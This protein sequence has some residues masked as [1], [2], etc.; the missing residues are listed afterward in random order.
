METTHLTIMLDK[1]LETSGFSGVISVRQADTVLYE[2][3]AGYADR[4]NRILNTLETRFGIASGTKFFT[5]LAIGRLIAAQKLNFATK[6]KDCL[7]LPFPRYSP[8]ITIGH[9]LT[10]TSGIPDY[11]D[12]EKITDFN[13]FHLAIPWYALKGPRDYLPL[14]PDEAMKFAPGERFSYSNG[15]YILLGVVIEELTGRKYQDFVEQEIFKTIGMNHSGYFALNKLPEKTAVGYIEEGEGW[16]TN[17]YNL[18]IV[19]ASDGGAFTTVEDITA[20]W[21]AFWRNEIIPKELVEIYAQPYIKAGAKRK[22]LSYGQGLWISEDTH[23]HRYE[24]IT[25]SDAGVSFRSSVHRSIELQI[26]VISNTSH[27]VWPIWR[28]IAAALENDTVK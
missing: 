10:H 22:N 28:E 4:S 23:G 24:Y 6:L 13:D 7:A 8:D 26:T 9:L 1:S 14:F 2:R 5:A 17:I 21:Q 15:G 12:E 25:G 19:G 18:P 16:R 20:L 3:A 27:G 11:F